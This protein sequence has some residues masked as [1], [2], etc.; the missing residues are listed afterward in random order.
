[1]PQTHLTR[2]I[3]FH[4]KSLPKSLAEI[5]NL[6]RPRSFRVNPCAQSSGTDLEAHRVKFSQDQQSPLKL[7]FDMV[8]GLGGRVLK[9]GNHGQGGTGIRVGLVLLGQGFAGIIV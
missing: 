2:M 5:L 7:L 1:M 3:T 8:L 4:I 6:R 9:T